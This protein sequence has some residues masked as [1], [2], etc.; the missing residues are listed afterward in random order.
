MCKECGCSSTVDHDHRTG[1]DSDHQHKSEHE[2]KKS[3]TG[4]SLIVDTEPAGQTSSSPV[5]QIRIERSVLEKNDQIAQRNRG[6]F[7][8]RHLCVINMLS[9]PGAGKTTLLTK[10]QPLLHERGLRMGV[11]VG[12]LATANDATKLRAAGIPSVQVTTGNICHLDAH[13]V[14]EALRY[15][16]IDQ[17]DMIVIENVGNLVCP[18]DFDL[19]EQARVVLFSVTE[20]EDKPE[21]YPVIFHRADLVVLTKVDL[22]GSVDFREEIALGHLRRIAHHAEVLRVS[23]KTGEGL[24]NWA[25][26]LVMQ[27]ERFLQQC[28]I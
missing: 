27:H 3:Q 5:R 18:A 24:A 11:V 13:M 19:G 28:P 21:K 17:L 15:L 1:Y 2:G 8:G 9:A 22:I 20:G 6:F 14:F 12:D 26:W 10:T 16:P 7:M 23:A 4:V 25:D